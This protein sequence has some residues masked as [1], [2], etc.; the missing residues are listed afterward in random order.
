MNSIKIKHSIFLASLLI[1]TIVVLTML[2]LHGVKANQ[3]NEYESYLSQEAKTA[4]IYMRQ[5]FLVN[6][7]EDEKTFIHENGDLLAREL[8]SL[9][10]MMVSVYDVNGKEVSRTETYTNLS[11]FDEMLTYALSENIAYRIDGMYIHYMA[12]LYSNNELIGLVKFKYSLKG[13]ITFYNDLTLRFVHAGLIIL[14]CSFTVGYVYF[15]GFTKVILKLEQDIVAIKGG[16]YNTSCIKRSDE[17]GQLS[18]G[19]CF[20]SQQIDRNIKEMN[21]EQKK[22]KLAID[23]LKVLEKQQQT[24]IGNITHEFK[25]PLTVINAYVDLLDAYGD[26]AQ[27]LSDAKLNIKK[28]SER[29]CEMIDKTLRIASLEIYDFEI[30][31]ETL[32]ISE[33]LKDVSSSMK[34]KA[35]K[36]GITLKSDLKPAYIMGD[37]DGLVHIFVNLIDNAIK[38]NNPEGEI[39]ISSYSRDNDVYIEVTD[40]GIGIPLETRERVFEPFYTV[41]KNR[42]KQHGGTGLGLSIVKELIEK[43]N[44]TIALKDSGE[45]GTTF[46]IIFPLL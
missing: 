42:S 3:K 4:N 43:Q 35:E 16:N 17:L 24:F 29:L 25:T 38:Y 37:K 44:G 21:D 15:N 1:L 31:K 6:G 10:G 19:I 9:C 12:P 40:T 8:Y 32:D 26:D 28:E 7:V 11:D 13:N 34:T 23:K 39:M 41:D 22:L 36:F 30:N 18:M 46:T 20:M 45:S 2:I 27:F 33:I 14:L 5:L